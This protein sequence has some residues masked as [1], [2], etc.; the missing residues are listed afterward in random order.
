MTGRATHGIV[1]FPAPGH[2]RSQRQ[3]DHQGQSD[4]VMGGTPQEVLA[5]RLSRASGC[6]PQKRDAPSTEAGTGIPNSS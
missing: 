1:A 4:N 5:L 3:R 2:V 6:E